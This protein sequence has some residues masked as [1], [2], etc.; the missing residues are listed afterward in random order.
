[1]LLFDILFFATWIL[2]L[3]GIFILSREFIFEWLKSENLSVFGGFLVTVIVLFEAILMLEEHKWRDDTVYNQFVRWAFGKTESSHWKWHV[4]PI[5][6]PFSLV[7]RILVICASVFGESS[8]KLIGRFLSELPYST[9]LL[10]IPF[11]F[12]CIFLGIFC[13][14]GYQFNIGYGFLKVES[15]HRF[16][17]I[18]HREEKKKSL[19]EKCVSRMD[20]C[21]RKVN[22]GYQK[23]IHR[24]RS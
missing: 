14:F 7:G 23:A 11:S 18:F 4:N 8:G 2:L 9:S 17:S 19:E 10:M 1:M 15:G 21:I 6:V 20:Y 24:R 22:E 13:L 12:L 16:K 5:T 3:L